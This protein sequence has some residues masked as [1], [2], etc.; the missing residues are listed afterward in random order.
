MKN[1][2]VVLGIFLF[3]GVSCSNDQST[4]NEASL[5]TERT[6]K[7]KAPS[8]KVL[9]KSIVDLKEELLSFVNKSEKIKVQSDV[10]IDEIQYSESEDV[11]VAII[12]FSAEGKEYSLLTPMFKS[13]DIMILQDQHTLRFVKKSSK[14][15]TIK[16]DVLNIKSVKPEKDFSFLQVSN[17]AQCI[18]GDC[19]K[20][21][22]VV[23]G[24]EYN[25]GCKKAT[26]LA[27]HDGGGVIVTTSDNCK[28]SL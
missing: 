15:V 7:L 1:Y 14:K 12:N 19:C 6:L 4:Q 26:A 23:E 16:G 8:G 17:A 28:I 9:A 2:I 18:N 13:E 20:W 27:P 10:L 3:F 5:K 24:S 11:T 21:Q 25:C 22:T